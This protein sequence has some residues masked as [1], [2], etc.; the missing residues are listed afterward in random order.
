M[1]WLDSLIES[2]EMVGH[3]WTVSPEAFFVSTIATGICGGLYV[4]LI[5]AVSLLIAN[6]V[7]DDDNPF[8]RQYAAPAALTITFL[9]L[10]LPLPW[11]VLDVWWFAFTRIL[12]SEALILLRP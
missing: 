6:W 11:Y 3:L 1:E 5:F 4:I 10:F 9:V 8:R 2:S 7:Y 12:G